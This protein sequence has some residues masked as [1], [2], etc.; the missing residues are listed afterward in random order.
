MLILFLSTSLVLIDQLSKSFIRLHFA[1]G[2]SI[3]VVPNFFHLTY[4]RNTGAAWGIFDGFNLWLAIFS[5]C[6]LLVIVV[7]R[8]M[9]L[10]NHWLHRIALG[11]MLGGII[12]NMMDR[13]RLF[14]VVDFLDFFHGTYH[15]PA[16]NVA[17]MAIFGGAFSYVVAALFIKADARLD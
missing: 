7:C 13:F 6:M 8:K 10:T 2:E 5:L 17:D 12:G 4:V 11:L 14:Y 15:F 3:V 16:F 9:F 1:Y